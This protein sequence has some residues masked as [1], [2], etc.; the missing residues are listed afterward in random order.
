MIVVVLDKPKMQDGGAS[1]LES[2]WPGGYLLA[3]AV[4]RGPGP[5]SCRV[6]ASYLL[7]RLGRDRVNEGTGKLHQHPIQECGNELDHYEL[8]RSSSQQGLVPYVEW[9]CRAC[10]ACVRPGCFSGGWACDE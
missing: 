1:V 10:C 9:P 7:G 6:R 5:G 3:P 2:R 4:A 8:T